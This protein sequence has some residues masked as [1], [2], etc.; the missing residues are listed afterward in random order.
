MCLE[1]YKE[2][3]NPYFAQETEKVLEVSCTHYMESRKL[4]IGHKTF[5]TVLLK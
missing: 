2:L 1:N 5:F 3:F 4:N